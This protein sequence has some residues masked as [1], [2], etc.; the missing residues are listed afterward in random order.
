MRFAKSCTFTFGLCEVPN[1]GLIARRYEKLS[2]QHFPHILMIEGGHMKKIFFVLSGLLFAICLAVWLIGPLS[3]RAEGQTNQST[4][5][6]TQPKATYRRRRHRRRGVKHAIVRT[7]D[8]VV[9]TSKKTGEKS[10]DVGETVVDKSKKVGRRSKH[11]GT[12]VVDKSKNV[13]KKSVDV[14]D[15]VVDKSKKVGRRS[16][17][18][19]TKVV[20]KTKN[21]VK[22]N[23]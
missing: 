19:G 16:K 20:D 17:H 10:V 14:G 11:V 22:P 8:K 6:N 7:S 5:A 2:A 15:T 18:I 9:D 1:A 23:Q 13:G 21:V 4:Q 3:V 12:K